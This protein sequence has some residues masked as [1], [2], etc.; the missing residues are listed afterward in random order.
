MKNWLS[1]AGAIVSAPA[2]GASNGFAPT[3]GARLR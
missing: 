3:T 1:L 2:A